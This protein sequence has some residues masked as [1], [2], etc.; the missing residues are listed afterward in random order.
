MPETRGVWQKGLQHLGHFPQANPPKK[1]TEEEEEIRPKKPKKVSSTA[2]SQKDKKKASSDMVEK[3]KEELMSTRQEPEEME[4]EALDE[5]EDLTHP[6]LPRTWS[7]AIMENRRL[8]E[9][10]E[11]L[12]EE[13][14][15]LKGELLDAARELP[16]AVRHLKK[17][18]ERVQASQQEHPST[19]AAAVMSSP[20]SARAAMS[21][22]TSPAAKPVRCPSAEE[23]SNESNNMVCLVPG[24]DVYVSKVKLSALRST[25]HA[26]YIGDLAV[27]VF[28]RDA[29]SSSSLT[30]RQS[31][32]HKELECKPSLDRGKLEALIGHARIKFPSVSVSE[33]R[34]IIRQKCNN[35]AY[36]SKNYKVIH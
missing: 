3:L 2:Q 10:N 25:T 9:L 21:S 29:L 32:A 8:R 17:M 26:S 12:K 15:N 23:S 14:Q 20:T 35:L 31:A 28:G 36:T 16:K 13:N 34:R 4:D 24:S 1:L 18:L 7:Q 5:P 11:E 19:T 6:P 33:V 30:G 22:P 27:V